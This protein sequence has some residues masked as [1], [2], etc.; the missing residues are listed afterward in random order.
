MSKKYRE[1][2]LAIIVII[3][4]LSV[5]NAA[6]AI[7]KSEGE[8]KS[9]ISNKATSEKEVPKDTKTTSDSPKLSNEEKLIL[10]NEK[11]EKL[12]ET[13]EQQQQMIQQQ[14]QM[15]QQQQKMIEDLK[16]Q[17]KLD[18]SLANNKHT[19]T[20]ISPGNTP[21]NI[22][23]PIPT[24]AS[25]TPLAIEASVSSANSP[26][27]DSVKQTSQGADQKPDSIEL[28]GGKVK[29][30][31]LFY[32]DY[33]FYAKTGFGPQFLTQVNPP[34]PGNNG[35]NTFEI[36]RAYINLFYSPS[37]AVTFR[38]TP[39]IF[40]AFGTASA[41]KFGKNGALSANLD[42]EPTYRIKFAY[43]DF[44]TLFSGAL[45]GDKLTIGSQR[46]PFV[47][48]EETLYGY[49]FVNL[50]PLNYAGFSAVHVGV[51]LH[52][53]LKI[54]G[55]QYIDYDFG[56]YTNANFRQFEM[57]EKKQ[58]MARVSFYPFA[59]DST[60][61]G[62]PYNF[63]GLGF[64]G[65]I[66][67]GYT[68]VAPDTDGTRRLYRSAVLAH[69]TKENFGIAGEFD[70][71]RNF[72]TTGNL[73]SGSGP[74]EEFGVATTPTPF[75]NLDALAKSLLNNDRTR[76]E[77]FAFFGHVKVPKSPFEVFGMYQKF[78]PN[79]LV[80]NNPFD[81][82]R[83]IAGISYRYSKNLRFALDSQNLS[84]TSDQTVFP[85]SQI[86]KFDPVLAGKNPN[87]IANPVPKDTR[88]VFFNVE[89]SF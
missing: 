70:Y 75:A 87:G 1:I 42:G 22:S 23:S 29:I 31:T 18:A 89:F 24:T 67:Y 26:K 56:V 38:L 33:A 72:F 76:Q 34:G 59:T 28:A 32:G 49:R 77:G 82:Q 65:F 37:E 51:S 64:T 14:Q 57:T 80:D 85:V 35:Y 41:T 40:R 11:V 86:L 73:F 78:L 27:K 7:N 6:N 83:I 66:D 60:Y 61:K 12:A 8:E 21:N 55:K 10:L 17:L 13:S 25:A 30:G 58:V 54:H 39:N 36:T 81:F 69:Y 3:L 44:N 16:D 9:T 52:G 2:F 50:T 74:A 20:T 88:A 43:V 46:N 19:V 4:W 15:I 63:K 45:K 84:Y 68:N 48:W 47:D 5:A 71:G 62:A 53:P 79:T